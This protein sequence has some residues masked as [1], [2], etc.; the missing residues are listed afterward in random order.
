MEKE[1]SKL[2]QEMETNRGF[3]ISLYENLVTGILTSDEYRSMKSDYEKKITAAVER[4]QQLQ[5][6]QAELEKQVN[7]YSRL[8]EKLA[9]VDGDTTLTARLVDLLIERITVN[10]PEDISIRFRF[11]SGFERIAEVLANE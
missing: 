3:L 7:G 10:S 8:A 5:K 11:D 6:Q 1:I 9:E 2:R 4:M